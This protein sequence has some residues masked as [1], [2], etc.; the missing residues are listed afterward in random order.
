VVAGPGGPPCRAAGGC[1][2]CVVIT[3]RAPALRA[4][5]A[6]AAPVRI[7]APLRA[8]V[9][10]AQVLLRRARRGPGWR[11]SR[12]VKKGGKAGGTR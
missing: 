11:A 10:F 5:T 4:A 6:V 7:P 8:A 3:R 12:G 1:N 9:I 2:T